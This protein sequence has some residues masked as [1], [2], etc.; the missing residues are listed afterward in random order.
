[1][2]PVADWHPTINRTVYHAMDWNCPSY[3][4]VMAEQL[5]LLWGQLTPEL[6]IEY[7]MPMVGTGNLH[8]YVADL[9]QQQWYVSFAASDSSISPNRTAYDRQFAQL[10]LPTLFNVQPSLSKQELKLIADLE[11]IAME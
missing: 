7:I 1:M 4:Q 8:T 3:N 6:A 5:Q 9:V 2:R 10:D 11:Q